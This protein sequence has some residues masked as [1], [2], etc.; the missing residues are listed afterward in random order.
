MEAGELTAKLRPIQG[1]AEHARYGEV[2]RVQAHLHLDGY[3]R[4][5]RVISSPER[6]PQDSSI[7]EWGEQLCDALGLHSLAGD[8]R[9]RAERSAFAPRASTGLPWPS[10]NEIRR[11][12]AR[13]LERISLA[14]VPAVAAWPRNMTPERHLEAPGR[15]GLVE[16]SR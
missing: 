11:S 12:R 1:E 14:D 16:H 7:L 10:R 4:V 5:D 2:A 6:W 8:F 3:E 13:Y 15:P 9:A